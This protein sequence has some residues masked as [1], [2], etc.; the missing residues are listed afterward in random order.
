MSKLA[1]FT[2][3]ILGLAVM[4]MAA[5]ALASAAAEGAEA[6]AMVENARAIQDLAGVMQTQAVGLLLALACMGMLAAVAVVG[7]VAVA[8][9]RLP[10]PGGEDTAAPLPM[11]G[12]GSHRPGDALLMAEPAEDLVLFDKL[13]KDQVWWPK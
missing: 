12:E 3:V 5:G 7:V 4:C 8:L 6:W 11:K 13:M 1:T 10:S 2:I 9:R